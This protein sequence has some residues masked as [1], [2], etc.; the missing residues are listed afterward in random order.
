MALIS[1]K[2]FAS[3]KS[4]WAMLLSSESLKSRVYFPEGKSRSNIFGV[5]WAEG[6][7]EH[8]EE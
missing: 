1:V 2:T 7:E 4:C 5:T 3:S 8:V 6:E